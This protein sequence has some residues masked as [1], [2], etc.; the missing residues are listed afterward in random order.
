SA[1]GVGAVGY[2]LGGGTGLLSR[3]HGWAADA[4]R[5]LDVVT[6]D[7]RLRTADVKARRRAPLGAARAASSGSAW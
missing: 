6:G 3:Q 7:G 2:S 1:S 5:S 4:V